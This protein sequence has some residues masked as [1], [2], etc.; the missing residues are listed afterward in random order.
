VTAEAA[1]VLPV[2]VLAA[3][4]LCWLVSL[5]VTQVRVVDAARETARALARGEAPDRALAWGEQ[6]APQGTRFEVDG[7]GQ[8]VRV[9]ADVAVTAPGGLFRFPL[10]R[11]H[12]SASAWREDARG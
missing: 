12:A 1:L 9:R 2:L 4:A 5:G 8:V 6:V 10:F 11:A 7:D 3:I